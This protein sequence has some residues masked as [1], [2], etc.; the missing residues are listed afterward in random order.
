[1]EASG[2]LHALAALHPGKELPVLI[3]QEVGPLCMLW[4]REKFLAFTGNRTPAVRPVARRY[5]DYARR[6]LIVTGV[7]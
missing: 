2:Q 3:R 1:M 5:I 6:Y 4:S 7:E